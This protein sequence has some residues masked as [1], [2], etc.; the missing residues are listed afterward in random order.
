MLNL[1]FTCQAALR[2]GRKVSIRRG[3]LQ[4]VEFTERWLSSYCLAR[5]LEVAALR[6]NGGWKASFSSFFVC[7]RGGWGTLNGRLLGTMKVSPSGVSEAK[8][9]NTPMNKGGND[10]CP[11]HPHSRGI[12][13]PGEK[14]PERTPQ[15]RG[16]GWGAPASGRA[17]HRLALFRNHGVCGG[18]KRTTQLPTC[19]L[20]EEEPGG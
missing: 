1:S 13:L 11:S 15:G 3:G 2:L 12:E 9:R 20:G 6:V 7:Y 8:A 19:H 4:V 5:V 16:V 18:R 17:G 14:V 10:R